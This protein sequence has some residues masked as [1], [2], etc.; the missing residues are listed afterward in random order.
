MG[1]VGAVVVGAVGVGAD[2]GA[3]VGAEVGGVVGDLVGGGHLP[4]STYMFGP[5]L[6]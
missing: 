3:M 1:T 6:S 4:V 5:K 2:V